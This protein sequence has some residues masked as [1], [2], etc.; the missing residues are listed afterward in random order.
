ML[1]DTDVLLDVALDRT[2]HATD[3][4]ALLRAL[5]GRP[6]QAFVAWHTL[7]NLSYLLRGIEGDEPREFLESLIGFLTI[8]PGDGEAFRRATALRMTDFEDAMQV[9]A[10]LEAGCAVVVTRNLRDY[11]NAPIEAVPPSEAVR[12]L[13]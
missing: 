4:I 13:G 12:R 11:V 5:E 9:G 1:I 3:S 2:P 8:A 7:A 10:A 6:K